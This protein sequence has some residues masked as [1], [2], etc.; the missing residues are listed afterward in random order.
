MLTA[1]DLA[2]PAIGFYRRQ[3][4]SHNA[5]PGAMASSGFSELD[6]ELPG[7]AWPRGQIIELLVDAPGPSEVTLCLPALA[8]NRERPCLWVLPARAG[9]HS[10]SATTLPFARQLAA[11]GLDPAR[12][13]VAQPAAARET[14]WV[15]EQ[16]LRSRQF[17]AVV[18]WLPTGSGDGDRRGLRRLQGLAATGDALSVVVRAADAEQTPSSAGV[19]LAIDH[20]DSAGRIQVRLLRRRGRPLIEPLGL[21]LPSRQPAPCVR[22]L[23]A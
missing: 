13:F 9:V 21:Q 15:L 22:A 11:A 17:G 10:R 14:W 23:C 6:R 12:Q 2:L 8:Q 18:A 16:A 5:V 7:G 20:V 19:R 4:R 1:K 3:S